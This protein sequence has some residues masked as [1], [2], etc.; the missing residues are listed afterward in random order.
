VYYVAQEDTYYPFRENESINNQ[1]YLRNVDALLI[2]H[3]SSLVLVKVK[4][5]S[6]SRLADCSRTDEEGVHLSYPG[7]YPIG[8]DK[9]QI[10]GYSIYYTWVCS[11]V[12]KDEVWLVFR[13]P[14]LDFDQSQMVLS[15]KGED[16]WNLWN[17]VERP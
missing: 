11:T 4:R 2:P 15:I 16:S 6:I 7:Y 13:F 17:L 14:S 1:V 3:S 5:G 12:G 10:S 8:A 9:R